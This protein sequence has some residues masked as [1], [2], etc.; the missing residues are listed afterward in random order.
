MCDPRKGPRRLLLGGLGSAVLAGWLPAHQLSWWGSGGGPMVDLHAGRTVADIRM[1]GHGVVLPAIAADAFAVEVPPRPPARPEAPDSRIVAVAGLLRG[2][3]L[4]A[5]AA[6]MVLAADQHGIDWRLLPV[7]AILESQGGLTACGGNA[8]GYANC[9]VRFSSF[10]EG[11]QSVAATLS[12]Y[13][14]VA[15]A[16]SLCIWVSGGGCNTT[17]AVNYVYR[18]AGLYARL[19]GRLALPSYPVDEASATRDPAPS[20]TAVPEATPLASP[21]AASQRAASGSP[22]ETPAGASATPSPN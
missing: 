14:G 4:E 18:A 10:E 16:I 9:R 3:P 15:P 2:M 8:W 21:T 17:H 19:G 13:G 5:H 12:G 1:V 11:I 7:I 20:G 22:V 6:A